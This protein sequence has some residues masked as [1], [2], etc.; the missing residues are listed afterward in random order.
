MNP[1]IWG[2]NGQQ[3]SPQQSQ[4]ARSLVDMSPVADPFQGFARMAQA[5]VDNYNSMPTNYYPTQPGGSTLI[6][7]LMGLGSR[8]TGNGG[9][10]F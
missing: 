3:V 6:G 4:V 7:G 5:G 2:A 9:G 1:F 8:L 10:L